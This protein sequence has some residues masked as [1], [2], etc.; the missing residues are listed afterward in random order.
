MANRLTEAR[1]AD[2]AYA[3]Y[4]YSGLGH[5]IGVTQQMGPNDPEVQIRY[6]LDITKQYNNILQKKRREKLKLIYLTVKYPE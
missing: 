5:R 3:K 2:G 6:V 4:E 1:N